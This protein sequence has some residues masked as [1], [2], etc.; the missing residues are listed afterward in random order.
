MV[1]VHAPP[2]TV[3]DLPPVDCSETRPCDVLD[4]E[5]IC[6][7]EAVVTNDSTQVELD[8]TALCPGSTVRV[9]RSRVGQ[10][11]RTAQVSQ[12]VCGSDCFNRCIDSCVGVPLQ[13]CHQACVRRCVNG[14][15]FEWET[16]CNLS[17][18]QV[19]CAAE[20]FDQCQQNA[21]SSTGTS[22]FN[23]LCGFP[24]VESIEVRAS[25][26]TCTGDLVSIQDL[27]GNGTAA[28]NVSLPLM[29]GDYDVC[30]A[31]TL[32]SSVTVRDDCGVPACNL[33]ATNP[34]LPLTKGQ[35]ASLPV[36]LT[37]LI[38][39]GTYTFSLHRFEDDA[40]TVKLNIPPFLTV[41]S[42]TNVAENGTATVE[43]FATNPQPLGE[44]RHW[45][46][47]ILIAQGPAT[48]SLGVDVDIAPQCGDGVVDPGEQCDLGGF[49]CS[50]GQYCQSGCTYDCRVIGQCTGSQ[51]ACTTAAECPTGQ[52]CCGNAVMEPGEQCDDGNLQNGDCC[53]SACQAEGASCVPLPPLCAGSF[54]PHVVS[55][56]TLR[57]T[58]QKGR[59]TVPGHLGTWKT[60][61]Q[62]TSHDG[63]VIEPDT[64]IVRYALTQ[65]NGENQSTS[66]YAPVLNP[67]A[68]PDGV[69][70]VP[71][72][73]RAGLGIRWS[74]R[75]KARQ[76]GISGAPGWRVGTFSRKASAPSRFNV[77]LNGTNAEIGM[78]ELLDGSRR[79]RAT[80]KVGAN[81]IT[82]SLDCFPNSRLER[83]LCTERR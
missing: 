28:L 47:V 11:T 70:F 73:N 71:K 72:H 53:S 27:A 14:V 65:N 68:C 19:E 59:A 58:L 50:P 45:A 42:S 52:G 78:P 34:R 41:A 25:N 12:T 31:G 23:Q 21:D 6:P 13:R 18:L 29:P 24:L 10:F 1:T 15:C 8:A 35:S 16:R 51:A 61:G 82:R 20:C 7:Q 36:E 67:L 64:S 56:P 80:L 81:C 60:R 76:P 55:N 22:F 48:C 5:A 62:F 9:I 2:C 44:Q 79:I 49:N 38:A 57:V 30:M 83:F 43:I 17:Q 33:T 46:N 26:G 3:G 4:T 69:C 32:L 40:H 75:Q 77:S 54:G 37:N 74:F 66:L 63:Q 39:G